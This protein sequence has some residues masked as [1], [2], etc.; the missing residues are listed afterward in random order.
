MITPVALV[1]GAGSGIGRAV[2]EAFSAA[3]HAVVLVGRREDALRATQAALKPGTMALISVSDLSI[4]GEAERIVQ[5]AVHRLG[6][7]DCLINNAGT[8]DLI[9]VERTT[10]ADVERAWRI[11]TLAPAALM[12]AA[13]PIFKRQAK[14]GTVAGRIITVSSMASFD[15]F[16]GFFAYASSKAAADS[17]TLS[18]AKEGNEL[19]IKAFS[20]NPGAVETPMLRKSFDTTTLPRDQ[21]LDPSTVAEVILQCGLGSHDDRTGQRIPVLSPTARSWYDTWSAQQKL[22]GALP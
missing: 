7:L 4:S 2:A 11:N 10:P 21:T 5:Q 14:P 15:P 13:W 17:L 19:G 1:T 3:G 20:I 9:P 22:P 16:P 8:G 6:R 12:L 18:A